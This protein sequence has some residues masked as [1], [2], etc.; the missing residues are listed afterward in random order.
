MKAPS[1]AFLFPVLIVSLIV[2][3]LSRNIGD[4]PALGPLFD[5]FVGLAQNEKPTGRA[6]A[7]QLGALQRP[8]QVYFDEREVPH[9]FAGDQADMFFAQGYVTASL[10]LW[11]MDFVTYASAGRLAEVFG[12]KYLDKDRLQRRL[13]ILEAAKKSLAFIEQDSQTNQVLTAYTKGVNA[14]ISQLH[15]KDYPVEYKVFA[16]RPEPWSKLKTVLIMKYM[17]TALSGYE[18]DMA[19]SSMR[20]ALGKDFDRVYPEWTPDNSPLTQR[21]TAQ[22][23]Q[24][25]AT[26]SD[27]LGYLNYAFL[28][29]LTTVTPSEYNAK[30]G[31]NNWVVSG[32]KTKS[33]N[34]ILC[35]DLHLSLSL[36]AIW[37]EMQL[38]AP[39]IN[40]YGVSI[41]GAPAI[42]VGFNSA[43][44]W[45]TTNGA[46]DVKDWYK[47]K[48]A[49]NYS[50]YEFDGKWLKTTA[51][52]EEI[53]VR[54][55]AT[56]YDTV[57]STVHGP[58]VMD[59][60]FQQKPE[61]LNYALRWELHNPANEILTFIK[62]NTAANYQD[63]K[64]AISHYACP[65]QN[66]IF[67]G[68]N[69][70]IA[71]T[72]QGKI[73]RKW[74]GQG[75]FVLDGTKK[76]HLPTSYIPKDSLPESHN[77]GSGYLFSANNRPTGAAYPYYYSGYYSE[78]RAARIQTLLAAD[79]QFDVAKMEKMQLDN[80]NGFA[81]QA[82]PVLLAAL[83]R[84]ALNASQRKFLAAIEN[85]RGDYSQQSTTAILFDLWW[86]NV[87]DYTW[88]E[89][90]S[91]SFY[92]QAPKDE[93]LLQLLARDPQHPY[94]NRINT[95]TRETAAT[96]VQSSFVD[97]VARIEERVKE[98][99]SPEW[100]QVN[101]V[102]VTHLST[103]AAFSRKDIESAGNPEAINAVSKNWGPSW[104]MIVELGDK[105][106][107]Y[108]IYPGGQSGN[109]G[110]P[111]YTDFIDDWQKGN[112]YEL[113]FYASER[114][115]KAACKE[116]AWQLS[117]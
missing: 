27:S 108:G 104:R 30:L 50:A 1:I 70:D 105:P 34:P 101:K 106:K 115:A 53:K 79:N 36:P 85:W 37:L 28:E 32:K 47:L 29:G 66:F 87:E 38:A 46:T 57:Y 62:L 54:D 109:V 24:H 81:A 90:R 91:Y 40:V 19:M 71:I 99:A 3:V 80:T 92:A 48:I 44:A 22:L 58:I 9:I 111:H 31:S 59:R 73:A 72:H 76:S 4:V 113:H 16:T 93:V 60:R 25:R 86:D 100:G 7:T 56:L 82:M 33:G 11:Q 35:N 51:R 96:I 45:G 18:E 112:Y 23:A 94:F 6:L 68:K 63:Y 78:T 75:R 21:A 42:I 39:G 17:A 83:D 77:P 5:P 14:Y 97:A 88:D 107:A 41:P 13:G 64:A 110:S 95:A 15:Y 55:A 20:L 117:N 116:A 43:I 49:D 89:L 69:D 12:A 2:M 103:L 8:V 114:E 102:N 26:N 61:M 84:T 65:V 98:G 67:A 10:R 52:V 74:A